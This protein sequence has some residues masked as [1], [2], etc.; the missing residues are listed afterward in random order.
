MSNYSVN[1][2]LCSKNINEESILS[3]GHQPRCNFFS[4]ETAKVVERTELTVAQ[5]TDCGLVQLVKFPDADL[6]RPRHPWISYN[7]PEEHLTD[8]ANELYGLLRHENPT[9]LSLGPFDKP[10]IRKFGATTQSYEVLLTKFAKKKKGTFPYLETYQNP[11]KSDVLF[12]VKNEV[13]DKVD[14]IVFRYLLEHCID[15]I[16]TLKSLSQLINPEGCIYIEVPDSRKFIKS[17]D[18]SFIWEEHLSYFTEETFRRMVAVAGFDVIKS[19]RFEAVLED[20][21][22]FVLRLSSGLV[23]DFPELN[24]EELDEFALYKSN[25]QFIKR[26]YGGKLKDLI[27][28]GKKV[29]IFGAGHHAIM[30]VN[31]LD[32]GEYIDFA[33]D[34]DSHKNGYIFPGTDALILSTKQVIGGNKANVVLLAISPKST[35]KVINKINFLSDSKV[36]IYS[37]YE[38]SNQPSLMGIN[39]AAN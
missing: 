27:Q 28:A 34:D 24:N 14:M 32:I 20:S 16:S 37:I 25:Y 10:L 13:G 22:G 8:V 5:C 35:E 4:H 9:V 15:P 3:F 29:A 39:C 12:R 6:I 36:D 31:A 18:Y 7:E 30:F 1:C 38:N 19:F 17:L 21:L 2:R 11:I 26:Q 33:I 23:K